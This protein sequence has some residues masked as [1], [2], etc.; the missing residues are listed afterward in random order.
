MCLHVRVF[1]GEYSVFSK[2]NY[3]IDENE[4]LSEY[5]KIPLGHNHTNGAV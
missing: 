2:K 1:K 3:I 5:N 4:S